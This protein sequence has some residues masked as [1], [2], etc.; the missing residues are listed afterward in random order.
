MVAASAFGEDYELDPKKLAQRYDL[1]QRIVAAGVPGKGGYKHRPYG[2]SG[3]GFGAVLG[4]QLKPSGFGSKT[5]PYGSSSAGYRPVA[6]APVYSSPKTYGGYDVSKLYAPQARNYG[7]GNTVPNYGA[8]IGY[9]LGGGAVHPVFDNRN[10]YKPKAQT[11]GDIYGESY[12]LKEFDENIILPSS[13]SDVNSQEPIYLG[14]SGAGFA[15]AKNTVVPAKKLSPVPSSYPRLNPQF[16]A[17]GYAGQ[18][19]GYTGQD[20]IGG[21][22]G[23]KGSIYGALPGYSNQQFSQY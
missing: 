20:I 12:F 23:Q 14:G 8:N 2:T 22:T 4:S 15:P 6:R 19:Q 7:Y 5:L 9:K 18:P 17:Y 10:L 1:I 21:Y 16:N 13:L 3:K 11:F